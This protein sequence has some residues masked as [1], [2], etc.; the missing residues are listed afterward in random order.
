MDIRVATFG[1][2]GKASMLLYARP[3]AVLFLS[4]VD[5]VTPPRSCRDLGGGWPVVNSLFAYGQRATR[6]KHFPAAG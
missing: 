1:G 2:W 5:R 3:L 6:Q 4:A